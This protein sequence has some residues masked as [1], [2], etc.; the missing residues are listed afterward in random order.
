MSDRRTEIIQAL[1]LSRQKLKGVISRLKPEDWERTIQEEDQRWTVRQILAHLVS[2]QKGMFNQI[3]GISEGKE[4]VPPDFDLNRWN[5]RSVEKSAERNPQDL[6][7]TLDADQ[8]E[9]K[10]FISTLPEE[11]FDKQGRHG[12]LRIMSIQEIGLLIA[13]H[14][15][16]HTQIIVDKLGLR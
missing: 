5:R 15:A 12:S 7:A 1:E 14:E 9:L 10:R 2:G 16:D 11:S 3:V 6:L 8:V 4:G 13:S